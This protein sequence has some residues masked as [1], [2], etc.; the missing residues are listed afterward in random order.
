MAVT[1]S[2]L[3]QLVKGSSSSPNPATKKTKIAPSAASSSPP[4][5]V[6]FFD[7][8]DESS[9][10]G[11]GDSST[12]TGYTSLATASNLSSSG[13]Y[14]DLG[15]GTATTVDFIWFLASV[16]AKGLLIFEIFML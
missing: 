15:N 8:D 10:S 7:K 4:S 12:N 14:N 11:F 13:C 9:S 2:V 3:K 1:V 5:F 6:P 16:V